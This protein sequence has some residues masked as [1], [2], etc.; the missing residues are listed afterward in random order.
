MFEMTLVVV[1]KNDEDMRKFN[2]EHVLGLPNHGLFLI[3]NYPGRS[4]AYIANSIM[5][6]TESSVFGLAH[7]DMEFGPGSLEAFYDCAIRGAVC[8]ACG[9]TKLYQDSDV[10]PGDS[11]YVWSKDWGHPTPRQLAAGYPANPSGPCPVSTLDSSCIFFKSDLGFRFDD[12]IFDG[13][14]CYG[15]DLCLQAQSRGIPVLVPAAN[16]WHAC[17]DVN[18]PDWGAKRDVYYKR[19]KAKWPGLDFVTT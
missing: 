19:L 4:L 14:H 17:P 15:E 2:L 3:G 5:D 16:A 1:A 8:G 18:G 9:R 10:G 6:K 13:F 7:A 11:S 12:V